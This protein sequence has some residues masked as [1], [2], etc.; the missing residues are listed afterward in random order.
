MAEAR[1]TVM[2]GAG[3][4]GEGAGRLRAEGLPVGRKERVDLSVEDRGD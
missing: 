2:R 3:V 4:V 1:G